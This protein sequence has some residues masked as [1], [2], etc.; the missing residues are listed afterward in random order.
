MSCCIHSSLHLYRPIPTFVAQCS[1]VDA[2][3]VSPLVSQMHVLGSSRIS[4]SISPKVFFF[5]FTSFLSPDKH[6]A[7][8]F[9]SCTMLDHASRNTANQTDGVKDLK[10]TAAF[11]ACPRISYLFGF[12][13]VLLYY[14][15]A[16]KSG[17]HT[18]WFP[19]MQQ[20]TESRVED[21]PSFHIS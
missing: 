8:T 9:R 19:R 13:V 11:K 16:H 10:K 15:C 3:T 17:V 4:C 20:S 1:F 2:S 18:T 21:D 12:N 14:P 6:H 5:K 7:H